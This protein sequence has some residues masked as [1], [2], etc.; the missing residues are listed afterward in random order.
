MEL[1]NLIFSFFFFIIYL[2]NS[3]KLIEDKNFPKFNSTKPNDNLENKLN[4]LLLYYKS[5]IKDS[6]KD[7]DS[8]ISRTKFEKD[9]EL[10]QKSD[11]NFQNINTLLQL[12]NSSKENVYLTTPFQWKKYVISSTPP[13]PRRG[14][15]STIVD[16]Y[17][18]IFGGCYMESKCFNDLY[19]FDMR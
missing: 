16:N 11:E 10:F 13:S 14:H 8:Q 9:R 2:S 5:L 3:V 6:Q 18:I 15:S 1:F 17:I 19:F 4:D 7:K 12:E